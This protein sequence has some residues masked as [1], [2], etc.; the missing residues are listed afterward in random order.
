MEGAQRRAFLARS[1]RGFRLDHDRNPKL[2]SPSLERPRPSSPILAQDARGLSS[3]RLASRGLVRKGI[4]GKRLLLSSP[5]D[6]SLSLSLL[7]FGHALGP[8]PLSDPS[9]LAAL[10]LKRAACERIDAG[11]CGATRDGPLGSKVASVTGGWAFPSLPPSL[12][13]FCAPPFH[14][15]PARSLP[16]LTRFYTAL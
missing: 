15:P 9:N 14:P 5:S 1:P 12:A 8:R 2:P 6:A 11:A 10:S 4:D 3:P 7:S 13:S 16:P